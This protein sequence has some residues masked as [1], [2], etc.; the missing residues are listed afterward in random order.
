MVLKKLSLLFFGAPTGK[1]VGSKIGNLLGTN[2]FTRW[3]TVVKLPKMSGGF[4]VLPHGNSQS[5][6]GINNQKYKIAKNIRE[7]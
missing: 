4:P 6:N 7:A 2:G 3:S 5:D 1:P